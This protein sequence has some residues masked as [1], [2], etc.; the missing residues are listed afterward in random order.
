MRWKNKKK[1]WN[2]EWDEEWVRLLKVLFDE[3]DA[4]SMM[5]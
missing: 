2:K 1:G 4:D 5:A 3:I